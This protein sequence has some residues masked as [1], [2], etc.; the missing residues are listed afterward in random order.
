[1]EYIVLI[2]VAFHDCVK[3]NISNEVFMKVNIHN[4]RDK[5]GI[6]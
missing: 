5:Y 2:T 6:E 1:M 3:T 4:E